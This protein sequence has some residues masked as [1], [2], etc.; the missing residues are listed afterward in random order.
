M[1]GGMDSIDRR[2]G[3]A[4]TVGASRRIL[5]GAERAAGMD[6]KR[7]N[8][9]KTAQGAARRRQASTLA[10]DGRDT[11]AYL[12][13]LA[14]ERMRYIG[15]WRIVG[16]S[17]WRHYAHAHPFYELLYFVQGG[18]LVDFDG[19]R[20]AVNP[21]AMILYPPRVRHHEFPNFQGD[22]HHVICA[23]FDASAPMP[24]R[25]PI[26]AMDREG[27]LE[28]LF[29]RLHEE[30]DDEPSRSQAVSRDLIRVIL[31]FAAKGAESTDERNNRLVGLAML[32]VQDHIGEQIGVGRIARAVGTSP[33]Y[34]A[35]RFARELGMSPTRYVISVRMQIAKRKLALT[36]E[37]IADIADSLGY[38]DPLY[39][40]RLFR[41]ATG[42]SPRGF[43]ERSLAAAETRG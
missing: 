38:A 7:T 9:D 36:D 40:S 39:F 11:S 41:G 30:T 16:D 8:M 5:Y 21:Y 24:R 32:Y 18:T 6:R 19:S 23:H 35:R 1:A 13:R 33:A 31:R 25:G 22:R 20:A 2:G 27:H 29:Q 37:R 42:A 12:M 14:E 17:G 15:A 10:A 28:W 26:I 34:L 4:G 3:D 43:R